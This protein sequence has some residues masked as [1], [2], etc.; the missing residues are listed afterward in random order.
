MNNL[1]KKLPADIEPLY[2]LWILFELKKL[3]KSYQYKVFKEIE[4]NIYPKRSK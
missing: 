4:N 3:S 2:G 1:D